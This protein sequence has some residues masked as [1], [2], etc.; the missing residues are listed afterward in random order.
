[1]NTSRMK[2]LAA[3]AVAALTTVPS[4]CAATCPG[5]VDLNGSWEFRFEEGMAAE[6]AFVA[7]FA[8]TDTMIVPGCF[9][10]MHKWL[11]KKGTGLC[12]M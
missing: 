11:M 10:M 5:G 2:T 4:M 7:D 12:H 8:A 1:M 6:E 3:I 9:D